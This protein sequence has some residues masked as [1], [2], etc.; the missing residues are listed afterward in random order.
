MFRRTF[1]TGSLALIALPSSAVNANQT[2]LI[3]DFSSGTGVAL[4]GNQWM[5]FTDQVM[6]G[7]STATSR[8]DEIDGRPCIRLTGTVNTK[9]G[10]FIQLAIDMGERRKPFDGNPYSGIELDVYGNDE[11][12]NCHLRTTDIRW[13]EQSYRSTFSAPPKW[14]TVKLPWSAFEPHA[15]D[16]GLNLNGLL[17]LGILGWMRDFKAD[18]AVGRLALF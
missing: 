9:G 6:G 12:Y 11:E 10:G 15:I 14:T 3:D 7:R 16:K 2:L 1:F 17:R 5:G 4:T 8:L 13:Y 18:I